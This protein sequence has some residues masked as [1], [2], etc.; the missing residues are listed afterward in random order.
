MA[1]KI[2]IIGLGVFGR[3]LCHHLMEL[4]TEVIAIDT[5][6]DRIEDIKDQVT[7]AVQLDATNERALIAQD[8]QDVDAAVVCI[9]E[10]FESNILATVLMK[11]LGVKQVIARASRE[12]EEVILREVGANEQIFPERDMAKEMAMRLSSSSLLDYME[13]SESLHAAKLR[14]PKAFWGKSLIDLSLRSQYGINI[15]AIYTGEKEAETEDPFP[16]PDTIIR[17]DHLLLVVGKTEDI[18]RLAL[19]D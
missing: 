16:K 11:R 3:S 10:D 14:A 9:G 12:I 4:G 15:I 8:I 7:I 5:D 17:A 2:A 13:L 6:R 19:M 18:D 1:K